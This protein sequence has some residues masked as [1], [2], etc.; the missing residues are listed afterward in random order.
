LADK[1]FENLISNQQEVLVGFWM[2]PKLFIEPRMLDKLSGK[3]DIK[4][5]DSMVENLFLYCLASPYLTEILENVGSKDYKKLLKGAIDIL[6]YLKLL[7]SEKG[8]CDW[9]YGKNDAVKVN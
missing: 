3:F 1:G 7:D 2:I 5:H 8:F 9:L 4:E 6:E